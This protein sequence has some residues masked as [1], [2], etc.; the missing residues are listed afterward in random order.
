MNHRRAARRGRPLAVTLALLLVATLGTAAGGRPAAHA[1]E[2]DRATAPVDSYQVRLL[3]GDRVL[4]DVLGGGGHAVTLDPAGR[5][6]GAQHYQQYALDGQLYVIPSDAAPLIPEVLDKELFNVTKLAESGYADATPVIMQSGP[7]PRTLAGD[8]PAGLTG[9]TELSS[10]DAVAANVTGDGRWWESV[11]NGTGA[12][13]PRTLAQA[14][15]LGGVQRVWLDEPVHAQLADSVPQI[16]APQAWQGGY[17]GSGLTVAVLDTGIDDGHP[18]LAGKVTAAQNFTDDASAADGHGHGTHVASTIAG[19]GAASGGDRRGVAPG[20]D[21]LSGKVLGA[22]G[23]G[24]TSWVLAGMEWAAANADVVNMSLGSGATAGT[25]PVSLAVNALTEQ[26]DA[27]FVISAG[28]SGPR[29]RSIGAPGAADAALTVGA[30]DKSGNLADFS[31]RGPRRGDWAIKPDVTAPGVG[32][33]AA[34]AEG[35]TMGTPVDANYTTAKGTSMAAPH[36]AGAAAIVQQRRPD[37]TAEQVK[38]VLTTNAQPHGGQH[39]YQQGGGLVDIPAALD[40]T[41]V[42]ESATL[43]LGF[44]EYPHDD[45]EPVDTEFHYTNTGDETVTIDLTA[46]VGQIFGP[47]LADG[48]LTIEPATLEIAPGQSAG[49]TIALDVPAAQIGLYGGYLRAEQDGELV[50]R[51]PLGFHKEDEMY[52]LHITATDRDGEPAGRASNFA[53]LNVD[54]MTRYLRPGFGT[55]DGEILARVP[56]GTYAI[57]GGIAENDERGQFIQ[58][59]TFVGESQVSVTEDTAVSFD[60]RDGNQIEIDTPEHET[61][62]I[63]GKAFGYWR[64]A[65][66]PGPF[67]NPT[68]FMRSTTTELYLVETEPVTQGVFEFHSKWRLAAPEAELAIDEP[69]DETLDPYLLRAPAVDGEQVVPVVDVGAGEESDFAGAD[70]TGAAALV[71]RHPNLLQYLEQERMAAEAGAVALLIANDVPGHMTGTFQDAGEIP[72][73]SI[74]QQGG[75]RLRELLADGEVRVRLDGTVWSDYLYDLML[76]ERDQIPAEPHYLARPQDLATLE[77]SY[78]NDHDGHQMVAGRQYSRPFH[79]SSTSL[80]PPVEGPQTRTEY[81]VGGDLVE[82]RHTLYGDAPFEARLREQEYVTYDSGETY[83]WHGYRQVVRPALLPHDPTVRDGDT[84]LLRLFPWVDSAGMFFPT[85]TLGLA[86][87]EYDEVSTRVWRDGEL[88]GSLD[89]IPRG[90]FPMAPEEADYRV[91]LDAARNADWWTRSTEVSTEWRFSS[92]RPESGEELLP[93]MSI[94]Y[95]VP[96]D[97]RN[98]VPHPRERRGPANLDLVISH[99]DA[100]LPEVAGARVWVSYDDGGT[101]RERPVRDRGDGQ[102]EVRLPG[103]PATGAGDAVSVRVEAWDTAGNRVDQEVLRAWHLPSR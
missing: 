56:P 21:L 82:Y 90:S 103:R 19:S 86:L 22:N 3:T 4:V 6:P 92:Q 24:L 43:D 83:Q 87:P 5:S 76:L 81:V 89:G 91:E 60:A 38:T 39:V 62:P 77:M 27:L 78:H 95:Q 20:A 73:L 85:N 1:P 17:D 12:S 52:D 79:T 50:S 71:S 26:H 28:N 53:V 32:I 47:P 25:D 94:D 51:V 58:R 11:A 100:G 84:L 30:V 97:L 31:S 75:E 10:I 63:A 45:A 102:F 29:D 48:L 61:A 13:G 65:Q 23:S 16:G 101:W 96:V 69:V 33:I 37:L 36:V 99:Q 74:T 49:A 55:I 46:E 88:V 8:D 59:M 35:T 2:P 66:A 41:V 57:Y 80:D 34:R 67:F 40:A 44:F 9:T 7:G 93:L 98:T 70:L 72:T 15:S 14:D 42:A 68:W 18:D 64:S 54:D